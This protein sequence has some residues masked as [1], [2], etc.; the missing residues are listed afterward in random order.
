M[1]LP[2]LIMTYLFFFKKARESNIPLHKGP[3]RH[4]YTAFWNKECSEA[5]LYRKLTE[6]LFR[7]NPNPVNKTNFKKSKAKFHFCVKKAKKN[8]WENY[9]ASLNYHSKIAN[10][11]N[12]IKNIKNP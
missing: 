5:K 3:F 4:I 10:I 8:Y 7:K 12:T 6:K 2:K 1:I 11:W 9:C